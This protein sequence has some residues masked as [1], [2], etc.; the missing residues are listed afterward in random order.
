MASSGSATGKPAK[1][2]LRATLIDVGWG[3]SIL[4]ESEDAKGRITYGLIDSNDT[5]QT[6]SSHIFLKRF[7]E[8]KLQGVPSLGPVFDWVLLTH[9][10][11]DHALGL[12]R[13]LKD[14]G[15]QRFW[16]PKSGM[17][18]VHYT[19]LVN[20]ANTSPTVKSVDIV[21]SQRQL[22]MFGD[23]QMQVLWPHRGAV[24]ANENDNSVV[25]ALTLDAVTF[26]MTGDAEADGVWNTL[27]SNIPSSTRVFK[28]P[29]H[30]A[31][32]GTFDSTHNTPWL[33]TLPG[34]AKV[35]ISCHLLPHQHPDPAVIKALENQ[36]LDIY[37]TDE[38]FHL[39]FE[40]DGANVT[41]GY[42]HV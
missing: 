6:R 4:L 1:R 37:R 8:R 9:A 20:F 15:A 39:A 7:F 38:Q 36:K 18:G 34:N 28:V 12:K 14:F 17:S 29:H 2:R 41:V 31:L 16:R 13:I 10:H 27:A 32:N 26:V 33:Q 40:T 3:D 30:G 5:T 42:T 24:S 11:T 23:V 25:L 21:D 19:N 22:P 35:A